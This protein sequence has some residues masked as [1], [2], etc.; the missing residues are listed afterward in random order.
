M[1]GVLKKIND[2]ERAKSEMMMRG[3]V[4]PRRISL[5]E[6]KNPR[7]VLE[8]AFESFVKN[9]QWLPE[10]EQIA[11]WLKDNKG[12]G[13]FLFGANGRGKTV[14]AKAIIPAIILAYYEHFIV[15]Y[16]ATE[17]NDRL[18]EVLRRRM[19][20]LDDIGTEGVSV[21]YGERRWAFPEIMDKAEKRGNLVI[22]TS[23][24]DARAIETKYGVRTIE[25]IKTMCKRVLFE[26]E[27]LRK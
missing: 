12:K 13:L 7:K 9:P 2:I 24:L 22:I 10:Y 6:I 8:E 27:S 14:L 4:F 17:I 21:N 16:D 26:G 11:D 15:A 18:E 3:Y 23:N 1:G 20:V 5:N 25:R 19:I